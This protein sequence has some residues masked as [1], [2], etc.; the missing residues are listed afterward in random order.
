MTVQN[1]NTIDRNALR[2]Q[3]DFRMGI[4]GGG[5]AG[6]DGLILSV[7]ACMLSHF[8]HVQL[9]A[10]PWTVAH[11]TRILEWAAISS[12]RGPSRPRDQTCVSHI[13]CT[14][15]QVLYH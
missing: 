14:G 10:T 13:S 4:T 2:R 1:N 11:Q 5:W 7:H 9:F 3:L 8:S 15:R 6:G 12:S